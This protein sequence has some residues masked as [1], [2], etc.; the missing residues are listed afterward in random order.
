VERRRFGAIALLVLGIVLFAVGWLPE[1]CNLSAPPP[2]AL[3]NTTY[4]GRDCTRP[5]APLIVWPLWS[6]AVVLVVLGAA[7][8]PRSRL[9]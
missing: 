5:G 2:P 1:T 7:Y 6:A 3:D 9:R 4:V 8:Y